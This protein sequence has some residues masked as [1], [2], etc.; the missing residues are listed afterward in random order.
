M[1]VILL[2]L[3]LL[4]HLTRTIR[5]HTGFQKVQSISEVRFITEITGTIDLV[6]NFVSV[7]R[8]ISVIRA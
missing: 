1:R 8:M 3:L 4:I 7:F 5:N 2:L 6:K